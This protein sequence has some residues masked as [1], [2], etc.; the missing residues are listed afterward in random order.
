[1]RNLFGVLFFLFYSIGAL[2][3]T[4]I[5]VQINALEDGLSIL[6]RIWYDDKA[7]DD[8]ILPIMLPEG[9]SDEHIE[10][11]IY[12]KEIEII[13]DVMVKQRGRNFYIEKVK[14]EGGIPIEVRYKIP[15][16][17]DGKIKLSLLPQT[18]VKELMFATFR[19]GNDGINIRPSVPYLYN[20]EKVGDGKWIYLSVMEIPQQPVICYITHLPIPFR[21]YHHAGIISL[22]S[23]IIILLLLLIRRGRYVAS[24]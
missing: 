5:V 9:I 2:A 22:G 6:Q 21:F 8:E 16:P 12:S 14:I 7:K 3:K 4:S 24:G 20:E 18:D 10:E 13:G 19:R 11:M 15:Y 23:T 1:M 17:M